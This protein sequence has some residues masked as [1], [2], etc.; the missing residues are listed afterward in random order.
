MTGTQFVQWAAGSKIPAA[1]LLAMEPQNAVKGGATSITSSTTLTDDPDLQFT[2]PGAGTYLFNGWLN[3]NGGAIGTSDLK[4][5][6]AYTGTTSFNVWGVHGISTAAT[7]QLGAAG[8][9]FGSSSAIGTSGGAAFTAYVSGSAFVLTAGTLKLQW[10]QNTS[11]ATA[12][13]L[14]QGCWMQLWQIA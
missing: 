3:Y 8:N 13:T 11:N 1:S 4:L 10:A 6:I 2:V 7:N 14:R 12:T 5:T 9:A